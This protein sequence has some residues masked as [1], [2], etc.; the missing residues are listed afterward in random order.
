MSYA[1]PG[2][3]AHVIVGCTLCL[4]RLTP[5][6]GVTQASCPLWLPLGLKQWKAPGDR[7]HLNPSLFWSLQA[8]WASSSHSH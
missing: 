1:P 5:M 6:A 8:R 7:W 2:P 3:P 4:R